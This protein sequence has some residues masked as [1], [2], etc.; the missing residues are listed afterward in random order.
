MQKNFKK[1]VLEHLMSIVMKGPLRVD[2][3]ATLCTRLVNYLVINDIKPEKEQLINIKEF[4]KID[5]IP[6]D[7]RL[8]MAQDLVSAS[9][10]KPIMADPEIGKLL[11]KRM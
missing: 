8:S 6:N 4:I 5:F 1:E 9:H 10:L 3:L 7:I 2:I 11:L